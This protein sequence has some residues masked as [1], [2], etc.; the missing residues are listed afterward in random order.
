AQLASHWMLTALGALD[1]DVTM[2][3]TSWLATGECDFRLPVRATN[4]A[5]FAF[6]KMPATTMTVL[7]D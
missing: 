5:K 4:L 7:R 1:P 6:K 2:C 3:I